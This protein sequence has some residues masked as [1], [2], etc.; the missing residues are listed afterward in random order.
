MF[1]MITEVE[2][3]IKFLKL[4]RVDGFRVK[5]KDSESYIFTSELD[6]NLE[7]SI[8]RFRHVMSVLECG[9][10]LLDAWYSDNK[11]NRIEVFFNKRYWSNKFY[12]ITTRKFNPRID[13]I[14]VKIS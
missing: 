6:K 5:L 12:G 2:N 1:D 7:T 14:I 3:V 10:F 8:S 4:S 9:I 13:E 11:M